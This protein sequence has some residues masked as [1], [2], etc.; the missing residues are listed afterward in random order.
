MA[1][2]FSSQGFSGRYSAIPGCMPSNIEVVAQ[3]AS[4]CVVLYAHSQGAHYAALKWNGKSYDVYND[5]GGPF[6]S[7]V[8]YMSEVGGTFITIW[9]ID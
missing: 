4:A 5:W 3:T 2:Y 7:I 8:D 9:C 1:D 6:S